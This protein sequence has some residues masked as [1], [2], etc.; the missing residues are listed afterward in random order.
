MWRGDET[1]GEVDYYNDMGVY[2]CGCC[3]CCGCDCDSYDYEFA[4][5]VADVEDTDEVGG[6]QD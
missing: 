1:Q 3:M 4:Y 5:E 6:G 2:P